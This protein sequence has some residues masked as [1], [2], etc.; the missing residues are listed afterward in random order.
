VPHR[1]STRTNW[2]TAESAYAKT[3]RE[4]RLAGKTLYDLT[5]SNPTI[6]GLAYDRDAILSPLLQPEALAYEP[7]A[8]GLLRA[9]VAVAAYYAEH[10]APVTADVLQLTTSTSEAYSYLFRLLC[11]PGDEVLVA[12]PGYPLFEFL[13]DLE[14]VRLR[15]FPLFYDHGWCMDFESLE[16]AV[17]PRTRA[18]MVVHPNNPTGHFTTAQERLRLEQICQRHGLALIV[19]EVFLDYSLEEILPACSFVS[20]EHPV[21]TFVLSGMSKIAAL[22]QMKVGWIAS[23][24]PEDQLHEALARLEVVADT[25]L[26]LNAPVQHAL[27]HWLEHR[28]GI[29]RQIRQRTRANLLFLDQSLSGRSQVSRLQAQAG[30]SVVLR[31]P[32]LDADERAVLRLAVEQGVVCHPGSF[33]GF[34][35]QGWLVLSLLTPEAEFQTGVKRLIRHFDTE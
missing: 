4:A 8:R 33:Y 34:P 32:A 6:C 12:Q 1:F 20:G 11:N 23:A 2:N 27:P 14:D 28:E 3:I 15:P 25:F 35:R 31:V 13:A 5:A 17:T 29:Q 18:L 21:L 22:P 30:W 19:D 10:G 9:R 7:D 26:S 16:Q 24:G